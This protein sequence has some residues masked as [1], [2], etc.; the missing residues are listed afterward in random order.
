[1]ALT[2]FTVPIRDPAPGEGALN[3]FLGCHRVLGVDRRFVDAGEN[4]FWAICVD[5]LPVA[6]STPG[7]SF[8]KKARV[9]YREALPPHEFA[10]FAKLRELR[11]QLARAEAVPVY[12]IFTND[13]LADMVRRRVATPA[14][15]EA[16]AGA[17]D[18]RIGKYG[19]AFLAALVAAGLNHE[20]RDP[21]T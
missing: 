12:T 20:A 14:D 5:Y 3:A 21:G 13:Q 7:A 19:P 11:Q 16:I 15:L 2:F 8:G 4:S 1:M 10:A 6:S 17:G 18:A 9:D